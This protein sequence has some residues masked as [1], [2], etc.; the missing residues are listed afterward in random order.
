MRSDQTLRELK[1]AL[2]YC[3][4][5]NT[6]LQ[7]YRHSCATFLILP[8][9]EGLGY[10]EEKVKDYFGHQDTKMSSKVYVRL[11][12]IQKVE[13][14]RRTFSDIYKPDETG[15]RTAEEEME[16]K[17]ISRIGGDNEEAKQKARVYRIHNQIR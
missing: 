10:T 14:T 15:E 16:L 8:P 2:D 9:P 13:R 1:K 6:N 3:N 12:E 5:E 11:G 7:M 4:M 17:I